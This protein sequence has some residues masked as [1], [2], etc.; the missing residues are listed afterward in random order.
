MLSRSFHF[1]HI[2]F[3]ITARFHWCL[4]LVSPHLHLL[5]HKI[6]PPSEETPPLN[7][8]IPMSSALFLPPLPLPLGPCSPSCCLPVLLPHS[9][10]ST[11]KAGRVRLGSS[12]A[13]LSSQ[14]CHDGAPLPLFR[15][16][17]SLPLAK[18]LILSLLS[19]NT[20]SKAWRSLPP[21]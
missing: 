4:V 14:V 16:K 17:P 15:S 12:K 20:S 19:A 6:S 21:S 5:S 8:S 10:F 13:Q 9:G 1:S 7:I 11:R 2:F 3:Y 18:P